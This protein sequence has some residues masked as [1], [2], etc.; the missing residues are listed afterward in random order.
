MGEYRPSRF[1]LAWNS[2][3]AT[4]ALQEGEM[5]NTEA[6]FSRSETMISKWELEEER[7]PALAAQAWD[8]VFQVL[9]K[10]V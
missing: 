1:G 9:G 10:W 3:F 8:R 6:S 7:A 4:W 5:R 2:T